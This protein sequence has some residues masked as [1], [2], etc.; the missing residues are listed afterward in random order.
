MILVSLSVSEFNYL[1]ATNLPCHLKIAHTPPVEMTLW[2][3]FKLPSLVCSNAW[4]VFVCV[5]NEPFQPAITNESPAPASMGVYNY[6]MI[7]NRLYAVRRIRHCQLTPSLSIK[8]LM[9][10]ND[11]M[12]ASWAEES[13]DVVRCNDKRRFFFVIEK[14]LGIFTVCIYAQNRDFLFFFLFFF[15][16]FLQT[17]KTRGKCFAKCFMLLLLNRSC[18]LILLPW[19]QPSAFFST[20]LR[21]IDFFHIYFA[22]LKKLGKKKKKNFWCWICPPKE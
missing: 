7:W 9:H 16:L 4:A 17:V 2:M 10:G 13:L 22:T 3:L 21:K 1:S 14:C 15:K 5:R 19:K 6:I 11:L 18:I 20:S 12:I 8:S